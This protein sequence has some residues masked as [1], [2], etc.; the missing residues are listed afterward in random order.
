MP[1]APTNGVPL[2][3]EAGNSAA[4]LL[5]YGDFPPGSFT[6]TFIISQGSAAPISITATTSG[7]KFL[8]TLSTTVSATLTLGNWSWITYA[9]ATGVRHTA[10][11][12]TITVLPNLAAAITPSFAQAQVTRLETVLATF[13]G[14]DKREVDF[15]G[16]KFVRADIA[17]YKE[18]WAFWRAIVV[19][20]QA[21]LAR[22]LGGPDPTRVATVFVPAAPAAVWPFSYPPA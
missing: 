4:F 19:S 10:D 7:T 9:T 5:S 16:Q 17:V 6:L 18:Q 21:A 14:T 15:Q 11:S 20:E 2:Q 22:S 1:L 3:I 8:V 13:A 12:G